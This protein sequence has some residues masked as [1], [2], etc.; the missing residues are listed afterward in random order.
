MRNT[1]PVYNNTINILR[2]YYLSYGIDKIFPII[3]DTI[4]AMIKKS[5]AAVK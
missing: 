1:L 2:S 4:D 3:G 5:S